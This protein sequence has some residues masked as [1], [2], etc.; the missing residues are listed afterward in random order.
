[1]CPWESKFHSL[2]LAEKCYQISAKRKKKKTTYRYV[3]TTLRPGLDAKQ[4]SLITLRFCYFKNKLVLVHISCRLFIY[5]PKW[6]C[7]VFKASLTVGDMYFFITYSHK[8]LTVHYVS[9][10]TELITHQILLVFP[11]KVVLFFSLSSLY[12][13]QLSSSFVPLLHSVL[14][15][16]SLTHANTLHW[17]CI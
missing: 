16:I 5:S 10:L 3:K 6:L 4:Y 8:Y 12:I 15:K 1:M 11:S 9:S 13:Q 7:F 17:I 14:T 2:G